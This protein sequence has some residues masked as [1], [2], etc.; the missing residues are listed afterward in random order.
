MPLD[1][2]P[3]DFLQGI[4]PK[5]LL[6]I[7]EVLQSRWADV[8]EHITEDDVRSPGDFNLEDCR[9]NRTGKDQARY[10]LNWLGN[11]GMRISCLIRVLDELRL[12]RALICLKDPESLQ[13]VEQPKSFLEVYEGDTIKMTCTAIGFPY[14]RYTWFKNRQEVSSGLNGTLEIRDA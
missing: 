3:R 2:N 11:H 14:P 5:K 7:I 1:I 10:M 6:K 4:P 8:L 13:I 12:E 9:S